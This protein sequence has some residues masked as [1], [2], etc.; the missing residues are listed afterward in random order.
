MRTLTTLFS[1][2]TLVSFAAGRMKIPHRRATDTCANVDLRAH[3][4][5][6]NVDV[7]VCA[8]VGQLDTVIS[9]NAVISGAISIMGG[10]AKVKA[11]IIAAID[12]GS[13]KCSCSYPDYAV[14]A[15]SKTDLCD[16]ECPTERIKFNNQCVCRPGKYDCNGKCT[17]QPCS[18]QRPSAPIPPCSTCLHPRDEPRRG[19]RSR[20]HGTPNWARHSLSAAHCPA[21]TEMCGALGNAN[22]WECVRVEENLESCGGCVVPFFPRQV[23]GVDCSALLGVDSVGCVKGVCQVSK[24]LPGWTPSADGHSCKRNSTVVQRGP[25]PVGSDVDKNNGSS[26]SNSF[27]YHEW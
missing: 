1:L 7:Q 22:G 16:F 24:C 6:V 4:P 13:G 27:R 3:I 19:K 26:K 8:C 15:C 23:P 17:T 18:S 2:L 9:G 11:T 20:H 5:L 12:R 14:P 21:G 10:L 25:A